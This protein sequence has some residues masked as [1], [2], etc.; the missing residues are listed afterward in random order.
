MYYSGDNDISL[1][2]SSSDVEQI[3][4]GSV[5]PPGETLKD[6]EIS[7]N[8][9]G[10]TSPYVFRDT[11][12]IA[13]P[14]WT[15]RVQHSTGWHNWRCMCNTNTIEWEA[16]S[17]RWSCHVLALVGKKRSIRPRKRGKQGGVGG[18]TIYH[19]ALFGI[20]SRIAWL[21]RQVMRRTVINRVLSASR[22]G[23]RKR[24]AGSCQQ[25][26]ANSACERAFSKSSNCIDPYI[27]Q[28]GLHEKI[29]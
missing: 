5:H 4:C 3:P 20:F 29:T 19:C 13:C 12:P 24:P 2:F 7:S 25:L 9:M 1:R 23:D 18:N 6:I 17:L 16:P 11:L 22:K 15:H 8:G 28:K 26:R 27:M 10:V 21:H 14:R